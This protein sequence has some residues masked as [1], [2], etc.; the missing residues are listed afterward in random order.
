MLKPVRLGVFVLANPYVFGTLEL[1]EILCMTYEGI[2]RVRVD[3]KGGQDGRRKDQR[4]SRIA[5]KIN[6]KN[7]YVT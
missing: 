3:R 7:T 1:L 5:S 6:N 2:V 4:N